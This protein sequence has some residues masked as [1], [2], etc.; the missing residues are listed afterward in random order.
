VNKTN[1]WDNLISSATAN[2][3][4]QAGYDLVSQFYQQHQGEFGSAEHII[5]RNLKNIKEEAKWS[6]EN[7]PVIEQW[8]NKFLSNTQNNE[9]SKFVS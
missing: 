8:L 5:Q 1:L 2:W 7:L 3:N 4:V 6:E 9:N